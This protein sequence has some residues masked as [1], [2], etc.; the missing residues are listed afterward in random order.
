M[1]IIAKILVRL[2]LKKRAGALIEAEFAK[3]DRTIARISEGIEHLL[4]DKRIA[5]EVIALKQREI[6]AAAEAQ[7]RAEKFKKNLEALLGT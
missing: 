4:D 1:S 7:Q 3:I 2:G 5:N 6:A